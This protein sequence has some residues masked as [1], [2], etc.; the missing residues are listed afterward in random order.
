MSLQDNL[1]ILNHDVSTGEITQ[2]STTEEK[3][4]REQTPEQKAKQDAFIA[5][6]AIKESKKLEVLAKLGLT[7]EEAQALFG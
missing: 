7:A 4:A 6:L 5:E 2:I 3:L 1:F